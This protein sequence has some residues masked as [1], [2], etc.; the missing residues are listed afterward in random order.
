MFLG[1]FFAHVPPGEATKALSPQQPLP[2]S[3]RSVFIPLRLNSCPDSFFALLI[4]KAA[5]Y[6]VRRLHA[7]LSILQ[8]S[9]MIV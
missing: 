1:R 3:C 2:P 9:E 6:C 8:K 7:Y 5:L 4:Q